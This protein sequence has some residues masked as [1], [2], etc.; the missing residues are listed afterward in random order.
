MLLAV[1]MVMVLGVVPGR[2]DAQGPGQGEDGAYTARA[3][4]I[5]ATAADAAQARDQAV[6]QGKVAAFQTMLRRITDP[7]DHGRLPQPSGQQVRAMVET[8]SLSAERTTDTTYKARITVRYDGTAVRRLLQQHG[9]GHAASAS[10]PVLVV[11]VYQPGPDA[12]AILWEDT[13]PWLTAWRRQD[14]GNVLMPL[15]VPTGDLRDVTS[16]TAEEALAPDSDALARLLDRYGRA[17]VLV[18]HAVRS[19]PDRLEVSLNYG[20]PRAMAKTARSGITRMAGEDDAA[21]LTRAARELARRM[22][23]DWRNATMVQTG[24]ARRVT[25]LVSLGGFSDWVATRRA[26][27]RS[28][29]VRDHT[30]QAM[31]RQTAQLTLTVLGDAE[32]VGAGLASEGLNLSV[33]DGYWLIRRTAAPAAATPGTAGTAGASATVGA[34]GLGG[35]L[36]PAGGTRPE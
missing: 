5:E 14:S 10:Q 24:A 9:I 1:V 22:E 35:A 20:S 29:L 11:P 21:F 16:L 25:A 34:T 18:A 27:E 17:Q 6:A 23:E 2:A 13:N 32:R 12:A 31:S 33:R 3:V 28:P 15:E 19:S 8:Y 26:L 7:A 30:V 36:G 4:P